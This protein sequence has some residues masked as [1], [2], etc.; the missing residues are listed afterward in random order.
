MGEGLYRRTEWLRSPTYACVPAPLLFGKFDLDIGWISIRRKTPT[1]TAVSARCD[2][3]S[4]PRADEKTFA[5]SLLL[6]P[7]STS[8]IR[9]ERMRKYKTKGIQ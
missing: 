3:C 5:Q 6:G 7:E 9:V 8:E 1:I 4:Y 2:V